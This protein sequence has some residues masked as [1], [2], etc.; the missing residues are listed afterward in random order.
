[1]T[2]P[3][4]VLQAI[5]VL[6]SIGAALNFLY[7]FF[8]TAFGLLD[9]KFY[10]GRLLISAAVLAATVSIVISEEDRLMETAASQEVVFKVADAVRGQ[11]EELL[12]ATVLQKSDHPTYSQLDEVLQAKWSRLEREEEEAKVAAM[13]SLRKRSN[14]LL[15]EA[16]RAQTETGLADEH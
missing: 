12:L 14:E 1:M 3:N 13:D 11:P 8:I 16:A 7:G 9:G 2:Y 10:C 15:A 4:S 6:V 5:A